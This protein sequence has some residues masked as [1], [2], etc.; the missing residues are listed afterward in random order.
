LVSGSSLLSPVSPASFS[1]LPIPQIPACTGPGRREDCSAMALRSKTI[2]SG[3]GLNSVGRRL[4]DARLQ[5]IFAERE[6]EARALAFDLAGM[7]QMH[8][9]HQRRRDEVG[10]LKNRQ[11]DWSGRSAAS[12]MGV[13]LGVPLLP[14]VRETGEGRLGSTG[15]PHWVPWTLLC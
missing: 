5:S 9:L 13:A 7:K 4:A 6:E 10:A 11:L 2:C 15:T 14:G 12:G 1:F 3:C 8:D